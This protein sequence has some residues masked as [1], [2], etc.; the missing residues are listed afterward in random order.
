MTLDLIGGKTNAKKLQDLCSEALWKLLTASGD[1]RGSCIVISRN[2]ALR[3]ELQ[4]VADDMRALGSPMQWPALLDKLIALAPSFGLTQLG[5]REDAEKF[6]V[7]YRSGLED[8]P[9]EA[10]DEAVRR[11]V[12]GDFYRKDSEK[13]VCKYLFAKAD[14][15]RVLAEPTTGRVL[16]I[17]WR[18]KM[19]LAECEKTAP[20]NIARP[21]RADLIAAGILTEDGRAVLTKKDAPVKDALALEL[22]DQG[23]AL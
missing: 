14:Q 5:T 7:S 16:T 11:W 9:A 23:E 20:T 22:G 12:A 10:F 3:E 17:L 6:F 18:L 2:Q 13:A 1:T 19:A 4:A 8:L 21:S 15:L